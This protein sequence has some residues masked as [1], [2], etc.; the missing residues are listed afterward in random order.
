MAS[1]ELSRNEMNHAC[2]N[3]YP[4]L[5]LMLEDLRLQDATHRQIPV[6]ISITS[7]IIVNE[8]QT[9]VLCPWSK[10]IALGSVV[11]SSGPANL[12]PESK[13]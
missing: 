1:L 7:I 8:S 11:S 12:L 6:N 13:R 9:S 3:Y 2:I 4:T 5:T 10:R